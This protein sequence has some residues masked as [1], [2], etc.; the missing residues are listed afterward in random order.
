[1]SFFRR[2]RSF[3]DDIDFRKAFRFGLSISGTL[4]ILS[5]ACLGIRGLNLGVDFKGGT[6]WEVPAPHMST[7]AARA[8]VGPDQ[9]GIEVQ[10]LT[11]S[12]RVE[13]GAKDTAETQAVTNRLAKAS[14]VSANSISVS[15]VGPS[16]GS[17][18]SNKALK[19][20]IAFFVCIAAYISFRFE[21]RMAVSA[22]LAV[23]HDIIISV[24]VYAVT[25]IEVTPGTVIAFLTIL[26][27]S[28]YDTI[29]V[30]DKI[31]D[32]ANHLGQTG[33]STYTDIANLSINQ[34]MMRSINTT[35][36]ALLPVLSILLIG[37]GL[38]GA[39][40]LEEFGYA[41]LVG[42]FVGAYSS[43]FVA[44]PIL[45]FQKEREPRYA[46]L[47]ARIEERDARAK[48]SGSSS[49][50]RAAAADADVDAEMEDEGGAVATKTR[51]RP[52][53]GTGGGGGG[54]ANASKPKP[55]SNPGT[56]S[57]NHPPRPR[58]KKKR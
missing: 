28:L 27:Y 52:S 3:D 58:K 50:S 8:A 49:S 5:I 30:F 42:L 40:T 2:L 57:A 11:K 7:S 25:Q 54:G 12:V 14:G 23:I 41:L 48:T 22:I 32:N 1:V 29:V 21:W 46:A 18:V 26:G 56:Y 33:K 24:G 9:R 37:A 31:R 17:Q 45:I 10:T 53:G 35:L 19:A 16:W 13:A 34:T 43:I 20:L 47:R 6:V 15:S 51:P 44:T 38:L 39:V 55:K 4:V 36:S